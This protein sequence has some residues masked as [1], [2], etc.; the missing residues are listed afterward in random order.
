MKCSSRTSFNVE[1]ID[2]SAPN[3]VI[4][5]QGAF[6]GGVASLVAMI[7]L[8]IYAQHDKVTGALKM[9]VKPLSTDACNYTF[10]TIIEPTNSTIMSNEDR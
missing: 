7:V 10:S 2:R 3:T 1:K 8:L 9:V 6:F 4:H 5:R